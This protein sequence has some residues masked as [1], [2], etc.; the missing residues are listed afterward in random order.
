M[1]VGNGYVTEGTKS[2]WIFGFNKLDLDK[3]IPTCSKKDTQSENVMKKIRMEKVGEFKH[4]KLKEN[5]EY[6]K[7]ICHEIKRNVWQHGFYGRWIDVQ[8]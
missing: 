4:L 6:E 8:I 7:C 2:A 5:P 3:V 1:H